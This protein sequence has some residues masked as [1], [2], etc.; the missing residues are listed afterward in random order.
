MMT[1]IAAAGDA[2][3]DILDFPKK[4]MA[5]SLAAARIFTT[6]LLSSSE[7]PTAI[8]AY[9]DDYA[10]TLMTALQEAGIRIPHDIAVLGTDDLP[11]GELYTPALS[12][13]RFDESALGER[14]V[15]LINSLITGEPVEQRFLQEPLPYL[16]RRE[17]T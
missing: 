17:S 12:T 6:E 9:S 5:P 1:A 8:Y 2:A 15:A 13:I 7:R 10:L 16:V 3:I 4:D 14:A 11:Y